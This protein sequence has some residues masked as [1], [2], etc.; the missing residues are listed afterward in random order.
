[1]V[2][3]DLF[4]LLYSLWTTQVIRIDL[5]LYDYLQFVNMNEICVLEFVNTKNVERKQNILLFLVGSC[6]RSLEAGNHYK[7]SKENL[8]MLEK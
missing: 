8:S 7:T 3:V 6:K 5:K 2:F 1:M 4:T